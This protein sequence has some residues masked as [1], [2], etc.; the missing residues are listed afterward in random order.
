MLIRLEPEENFVTVCTNYVCEHHKREP[1]D[2]SWAGC[3]CSSSM[4]RRRATPEEKAEN[5]RRS[6]D[7]RERRCKHMED[8]DAC[9]FTSNLEVS[10][11]GAFPPSA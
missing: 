8:Y 1:W 11:G 2:W 9:K 10:G 5:I 4:S 7:E 6:R 3:T